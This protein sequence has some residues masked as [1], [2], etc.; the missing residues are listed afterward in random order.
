MSTLPEKPL[1]DALGAAAAAV[2]LNDSQSSGQEG[3]GAAKE[4]LAPPVPLVPPVPP[5]PPAAQAPAVDEEDL[6]CCVCYELAETV[7][8]KCG[9]PLCSGCLGAIAERARVDVNCPMCRTPLG[10]KRGF[11]RRAALKRP[12]P[13]APPPAP[14]ELPARPSATPPAGGVSRSFL[15][16]VL[17][18]PGTDTIYKTCRKHSESPS[19]TTRC[20]KVLACAEC[21]AEQVRKTGGVECAECGVDHTATLASLL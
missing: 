20:C 14:A 19:G 7:T 2:A 6:E 9:H 16:E 1:R 4:A 21:V 3:G 11:D 15:A 5:A 18:D 17:L 13:P 8:A 10:R 12:A